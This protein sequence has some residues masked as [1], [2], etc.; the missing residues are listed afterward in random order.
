MNLKLNI[1]NIIFYRYLSLEKEEIMLLRFINELMR[2]ID[3]MQLEEYFLQFEYNNKCYFVDM[4]IQN[5]F[6]IN[7]VVT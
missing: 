7:I 4:N 1:T 3:T 6:H 2:I 5:T